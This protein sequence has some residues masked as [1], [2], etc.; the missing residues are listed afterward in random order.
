MQLNIALRDQLEEAH[1]TNEALTA[2]LQKLSNDWDALREEMALKE[3]EWKEEEQVNI[4]QA[5]SQKKILH[6]LHTYFIS[7]I[8][9]FDPYAFREIHKL[10]LKF[11]KFNAINCSLEKIIFHFY[12]KKTAFKILSKHLSL[13]S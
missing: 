5:T 10:Q 11:G 3:D 2:D 6:V 13:I 9:Y 12:F 8:A 1:Q 7:F 4:F